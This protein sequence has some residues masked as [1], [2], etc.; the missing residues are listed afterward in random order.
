VREVEPDGE[1]KSSAVADENRTNGRDQAPTA[2][3]SL[4]GRAVLKRRDP[5]AAGAIALTLALLLGAAA[6]A[7]RDE[8]DFWC[9]E[10][11]HLEAVVRAAEYHDLGKPGRDGITIVPVGGRR[12]IAVDDWRMKRE[13]HFRKACDL[14]YASAHPDGFSAADRT[15]VTEAIKEGGDDGL[16]E[17][18]QLTLSLGA[19]LVG[20]LGGY[21]ASRLIRSRE[22]R[23]SQAL[24]LGNALLHLDGD[25]S[26]V[27]TKARG[28]GLKAEHV[29]P[30]EAQIRDLLIRLPRPTL[31][32]P[33]AKVA[34][35]RRALET[36]DAALPAPSTK[37]ASQDVL[38]ELE[39]ARRPVMETVGDVVRELSADAKRMMGLKE[40]EPA[41]SK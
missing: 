18:D 33:E 38:D 35:A 11:D 6:S 31:R 19:A 21:G 15:A 8:V 25:L 9:I 32:M 41:G 39:D 26:D 17:K 28:G 7:K 2:A 40:P 3:T 27:A 30:V 4:D 14:A 1:R 24:V 34:A 23:Y 22:V 10:G 12:A 20:A 37:P 29:A 13:D 5:V 36:L 16:S